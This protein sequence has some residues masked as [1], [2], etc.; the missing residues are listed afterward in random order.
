MLSYNKD[1][2]VIRAYGVVSPDSDGFD[3]NDFHEAL[4]AMSGADVLVQLDSEGGS[5]PTGVSIY[6]QLKQYPGK[7]TIHVD[8]MAASIASV[9]MCAGDHV[10]CNSTSVVMAH[11]A[12]A[13]SMG[14]SR[15][16][17]KMAD[18]LDMLSNM[19]ADIYAEKTG[20]D[21]AYW[22]GIMKGEKYYN[23]TDALAAGLVDE[24]KQA[25][26]SRKAAAK[27]VAS[28]PMAFSADAMEARKLA[29]SL[30]ERAAGLG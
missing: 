13:I 4:E 12:W 10:I 20:N 7:V 17:A 28:V 2:G 11:D 29:R 1:T 8:S 18:V 19:I 27:A 5:V 3:N 9:I 16:F 6:N 25:A 15:E 26:P 21:Q 22:R 24:I 14:D 30:R 23:A